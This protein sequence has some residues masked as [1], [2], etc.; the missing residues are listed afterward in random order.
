MNNTILIKDILLNGKRQNVPI[1]ETVQ[2][3]QR[4]PQ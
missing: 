4:N 3:N 1:G 2:K